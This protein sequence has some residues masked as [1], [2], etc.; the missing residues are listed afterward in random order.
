MTFG[1]LEGNPKHKLFSKSG[2]HTWFCFVIFL[3]LCVF[4]FYR[5]LYSLAK[6]WCTCCI[7]IESNE[8]DKINDEKLP[9]FWN[10]LRGDE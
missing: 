3:A 9:E 10:A 1:N 2:F 5:K 8:T 6:E 4:H 7:E